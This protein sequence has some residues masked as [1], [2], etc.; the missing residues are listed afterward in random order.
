MVTTQDDDSAMLLLQ[1]TLRYNT[2]TDEHDDELLANL[3]DQARGLIE[4]AEVR[5]W[6]LEEAGWS[7]PDSDDPLDYA[8]RLLFCADI[9]KLDHCVTLVRELTLRKLP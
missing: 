5:L 3:R 4:E 6:D 7:F 8:L 2:P 1:R 9:G